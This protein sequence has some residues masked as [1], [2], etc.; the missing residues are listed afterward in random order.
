MMLLLVWVYA[1]RQYKGYSRGISKVDQSK[2][3]HGRGRPRVTNAVEDRRIARLAIQQ[4][5]TTCYPV[6]FT[7]IHT[8][9]LRLNKE[10]ND[11][12]LVTFCFAVSVVKALWVH[13][14]QQLPILKNT[15]V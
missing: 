1:V 9:L 12:I 11:V 6:V 2:T 7:G 14:E 15:N 10:F 13:C 4:R 3:I 8:C 5:F